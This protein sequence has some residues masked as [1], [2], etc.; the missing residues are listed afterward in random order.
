MGLGRLIYEG[1]EQRERARHDDRKCARVLA[2]PWHQPKLFRLQRGF[3]TKIL[4]EFVSVCPCDLY[5]DAPNRKVSSTNP[6]PCISGPAVINES[7]KISF[8]F[9]FLLLRSPCGWHRH[10][11]TKHQQWGKVRHETFKWLRTW[12]TQENTKSEKRFT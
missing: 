11:V 9:Q 2:N 12:T 1:Y 4:H 7:P 3:T 8:S 10:G 6:H 5:N